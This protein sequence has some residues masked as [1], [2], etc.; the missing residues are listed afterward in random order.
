[1]RRII[2]SAREIT[3]KFGGRTVFET[4]ENYGVTVW[5]RNLG[6]LKGFYIFENN[7][8]YIVINE[9]LDSVMQRV[10]C[11][12]EL[13]HDV[14]HRELSAGGIRET[15][16]LLSGNKTE[17]EAN[18]FAACL[19]VPDDAVLSAISYSD[20]IEALAFEL[21][22]PPQIIEYKLEILNYMGY[23]FN[24]SSVNSDFLK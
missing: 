19:L 11:A 4:A 7:R 3:E 18:L 17:R 2:E 5:R 8:R 10:V 13:G 21:D 6:S 22:L 16:L 15:T 14:L 9:S 1:M 23:S 20:S 24:V 12:H